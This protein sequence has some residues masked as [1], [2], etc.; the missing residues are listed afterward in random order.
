MGLITSYLLP[1][2]YAQFPEAGLEPGRDPE[3]VAVF[4]FEHEDVGDVQ[5]WDEGNSASLAIGDLARGDFGPY[6]SSYTAEERARRI[7]EEIA[8]FLER[9]FND[10]VL[11]WA[12]SD[13]YE[14]RPTGGWEP[15]RGRLP[16]SNKR[17][18][19]LRFLWSGPVE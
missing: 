8:S 7:A 13:D 5:I 3:P 19:I 10:E 14:G 4:P 2:L 12:T 1:E 9:L 11:I 15:I 17:Q 16:L 18:H 6:A